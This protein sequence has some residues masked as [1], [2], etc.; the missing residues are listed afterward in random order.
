MIESQMFSNGRTVF[1][2][3]VCFMQKETNFTSDRI[4]II[5]KSKFI[6][7]TY[8]SIYPNR[9]HLHSIGGT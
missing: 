6:A 9:E 5:L 8:C 3:P 2:V 4:L 1:F 7:N